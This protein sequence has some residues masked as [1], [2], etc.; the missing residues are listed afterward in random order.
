MDESEDYDLF[1]IHFKMMAPGQFHNWIDNWLWKRGYNISFAG[2]IVPERFWSKDG[3][4]DVVVRHTEVNMS[5]TM[6]PDEVALENWLF[7]SKYW[8]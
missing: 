3:Q 8:K 6:P 4:Q 7:K 2:G 5:L 1:I